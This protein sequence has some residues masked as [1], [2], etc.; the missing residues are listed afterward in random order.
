MNPLFI[1][2]LVSLI[3]SLAI[4]PY[5][6]KKL[7][8]NGYTVNDYYKKDKPMVATNGG[9]LII[10]VSLVILSIGSYI[11]EF[12]PITFR[13]AM[14]L[15][16]FAFTGMLD[17]MVNIG[18]P[19]K[20]FLPYLFSFPLAGTFSTSTVIIP[21]IGI[22]DFGILFG[23][24]VVP[25]Y[26][27]VSANLVNMHSGFNGLAAGTSSLILLTLLTKSVI[28]GQTSD[29]IAIACITG[30]TLGFLWYNRYPSRIFLGNTGA[31]TV[32]SAIGLIIVVQGF[33]VSGF[34]M[35]IPHVVN[36]LMY[37]FWRLRRFPVAKFGE[38]RDD[39]TLEVPNPLTLKWVLPYY[40]NITE[41]R[42]T[43]AML[44]LTLLFCVIGFFVPF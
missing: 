40:F 5:Y 3:A 27:M 22:L 31:L 34:V 35:L 25:V 11:P 26:I 9:L 41:K 28:I 4:M 37:V 38:I 32:G 43:Q 36:F 10:F 1:Y 24:F 33:F 19:M 15:T 13:I 30:A 8:E 12:D 39:G 14:I 16:L 7:T 42:T 6:I 18:R 44:L 23:V 29:V 21:I 20:M 2:L 17:D